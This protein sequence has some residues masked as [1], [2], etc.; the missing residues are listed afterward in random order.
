MLFVAARIEKLLR[1]LRKGSLVSV[2][3]FASALSGG[4]FLPLAFL[5]WALS[6]TLCREFARQGQFSTGGNA[7]FALQKRQKP[8]KV[9]SSLGLVDIIY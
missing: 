8:L 1:R 7:P 4:E 5:L 3:F 6:R 9:F 2:E